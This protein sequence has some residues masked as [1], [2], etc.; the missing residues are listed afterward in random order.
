MTRDDYN[1]LL[2]MIGKLESVDIT[3]DNYRCMGSMGKRAD[4]EALCVLCIA[5]NASVNEIR[6]KIEAIYKEAHNDEKVSV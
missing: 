4:D 5:L 3:L 2:H 1:E 6:T